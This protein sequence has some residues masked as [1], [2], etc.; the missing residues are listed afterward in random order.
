MS[1]SGRSL[2]DD[3]VVV[4]ADRHA[5]DA[6]ASPGQLDEHLGLDFVPATGQASRV[7]AGSCAISRNPDCASATRWPMKQVEITQLLIVFV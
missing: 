5:R 3:A 7:A 1:R 2:L 4:E 6:R